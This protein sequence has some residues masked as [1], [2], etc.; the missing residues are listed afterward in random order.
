MDD[1]LNTS[2]NSTAPKINPLKYETEKCDACG[3]TVFVPGFIF[4]RIPGLE[5]GNGTDDVLYPI[6]VYY[7]AKC[8][9]ISAVDREALELDKTDT[10]TNLIL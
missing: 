10:K 3:N 4:K 2:A 6:P 1:I 8:G 7:C 9:T 5:V